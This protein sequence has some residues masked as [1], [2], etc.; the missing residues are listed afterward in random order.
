VPVELRFWMIFWFAAGEI[1]RRQVFWVRDDA[2][3]AAGL[4][5]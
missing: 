4:A 3:E 1:K 5:E 2:L